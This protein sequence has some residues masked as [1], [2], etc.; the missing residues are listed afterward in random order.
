MTAI[1]PGVVHRPATAAGRI[2]PN[3]ILQTVAVV[4]DRWGQALAARI[5]EGTPWRLDH[6]PGHMVREDEV[7]TVTD[8]VRRALGAVQAAQVLE[9]AGQRTADYLLRHRIP[10]LAQWII[11]AAPPPIGIRFLLAAISRN[12]WTFAGSA[13]VALTTT[14]RPAVSFRGCPLCVGLHASGPA[15]H[16]YAATFRGLFRALVSPRATVTETACQAAGDS[17][18]RFE[19][20]P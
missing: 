2:G 18:C 12:R 11:R 15:C 20:M 7:R 5:L 6:L 16:F 17:C 3:A 1:S 10:R 19:I 14:P 8:G 13:E 4:S 9:E